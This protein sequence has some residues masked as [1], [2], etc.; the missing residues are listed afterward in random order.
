MAQKK[1]GMRAMTRTTAGQDPSLLFYA[2]LNPASVVIGT[3]DDNMS[4]P[5]AAQIVGDARL[6]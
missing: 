4:D 5:G 2:Q 6:D 1:A 3:I